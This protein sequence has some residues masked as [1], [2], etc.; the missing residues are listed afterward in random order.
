VLRWENTKS[1]KQSRCAR[2]PG[3][4]DWMSVGHFGE[5]WVEGALAWRG[6]VDMR[7]IW[8]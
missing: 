3:G 5:V 2:H 1:K 7:D 8:K 4:V 6:V